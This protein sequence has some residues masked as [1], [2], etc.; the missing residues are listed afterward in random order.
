VMDFDKHTATE[1]YVD[2]LPKEVQDAIR[3]KKVLV[4]MDHEMVLLAKGRP[5]RKLR[6][7]DNGDETEDWIYGKAPG[8]IT[9]VTFQGNKVINVK[10]DYAG[11]E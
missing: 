10:D 9:F 8:T 5:D 3:E 4:G 7:N 6:E 2:S 11:P 1:L